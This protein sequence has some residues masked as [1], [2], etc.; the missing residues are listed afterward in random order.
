MS[1][2]A[3]GEYSIGEDTQNNREAKEDLAQEGM[4]ECDYKHLYS[5]AYI[6]RVG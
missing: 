5:L 6:Y 3:E 1:G 2:Y 4:Q